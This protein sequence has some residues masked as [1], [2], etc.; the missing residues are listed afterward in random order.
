LTRL[1]ERL[2]KLNKRVSENPQHIESW[3][4]I[5]QVN[6]YRGNYLEAISAYEKI[7]QIEPQLWETQLGIA[8]IFEEI[9][10]YPGALELLTQYAQQHPNE[11]VGYLLFLKFKNRPGMKDHLGELPKLYKRFSPIKENITLAIKATQNSLSL[12]EEF[13]EDLK[14]IEKPQSLDKFL[15]S[16]GEDK[17]QL[18]TE[19]LKTLQDLEKTAKSMPEQATTP[20]SSRPILANISPLEEEIQEFLNIK[21]ILLA[22]ITNRKGEIQAKLVKEDG[23]QGDLQQI[24]KDTSQAFKNIQGLKNLNYWL[25]E[26]DQGLLVIYNLKQD[27]F[28]VCQ[29]SLGTNFGALRY[30]I[31]Q[32]RNNLGSLLPG[33]V[34]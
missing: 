4:N 18:L 12:L 20:L 26:Y 31:E 17:K 1:D 2:E 25:L 3:L 27:W 15:K 29:G 32:K 22:I 9:K 23:F 30:L 16:N 8:Q 5:A 24:F 21:G 7:K 19:N 34:A 11:V 13:I 33:E 10:Q 6:F 14:K 28:L